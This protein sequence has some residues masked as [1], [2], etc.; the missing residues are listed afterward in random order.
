MI[1]RDTLLQD[2]NA[3][4]WESKYTLVDRH[5]PVFMKNYAV[6]VLVAGKYHNVLKGLSS[7]LP[8]GGGGGGGEIIGSASSLSGRIFSSPNEEYLDSDDMDGE[9]VDDTEGAATFLVELTPP[10][11]VDADLKNH[12]KLFRSI[13]DCYQYSS[14]ALLLLLERQYSLSTH[15]RSLRR[16]FLFE[17]GDFFTQFLDLASEELRKESKSIRLTRIQHLLHLAVQTSTLSNE[18]HKEGYVLFFLKYM[19]LL[20]I[21]SFIE[22]YMLIC[23]ID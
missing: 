7:T 2:V 1:K 3:Q 6:K 8:S 13:E 14:R 4:Y 5:V 22:I 12:D 9:N 23:I 18:L 20:L 10:K 19:N 21:K 17:H 16:F 15:L 11:S